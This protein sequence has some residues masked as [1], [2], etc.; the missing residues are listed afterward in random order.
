[1]TTTGIPPGHYG[2]RDA[3][4]ALGITPSAIR[5][6]VQ[7]G[8]LT[9]AGGTERHPWYT[10]ADIAALLAARRIHRR[11]LDRRSD[12]VSRSR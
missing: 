1:M 12:T 9:R 3:A 6:I 4:R 8:Q 5:K 10:A 11:A 2:T 7:R